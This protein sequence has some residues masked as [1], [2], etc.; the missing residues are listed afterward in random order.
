MIRQ[1]RGGSC[2]DT[3]SLRTRPLGSGGI[4]RRER[5]RLEPDYPAEVPPSCPRQGQNGESIRLRSSYAPAVAVV[6]RAWGIDD[7][8]HST[9]RRVQV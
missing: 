6:S 9:L 1:N 8:S 3:G 5:S 4:G 7:A 2:Q